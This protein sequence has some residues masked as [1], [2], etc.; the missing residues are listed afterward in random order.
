[1]T[2]SNKM[3]VIGLTN[4]MIGGV[5]L[6]LPLLALETGW[7]LILPV[8]IF[9]G[10]VSYYTCSLCLRHMKNYKDLDVAILHHF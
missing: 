10:F 9:S 2:L 7:L 5:I 4:G 1:M 6:V 3:T 8:T